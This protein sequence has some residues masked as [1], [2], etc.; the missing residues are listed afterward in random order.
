MDALSL[1]CRGT[2]AD[3]EKAHLV[4]IGIMSRNISR[5]F[6]SHPE[7]GR[8]QADVPWWSQK[9]LIWLQMHQNGCPQSYL[10]LRKAYNLWLS[11]DSAGEWSLVVQSTPHSPEFPCPRG[12]FMLCANRHVQSLFPI[13]S[14]DLAV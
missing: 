6:Q 7:S 2:R 13:R 3:S 11:M 8:A 4:L 5:L 1:M 9:F 12:L 14:N 10:R